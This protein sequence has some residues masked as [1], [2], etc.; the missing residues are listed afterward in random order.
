MEFDITDDAKPRFQLLSGL[1][2]P[3]VEELELNKVLIGACSSVGILF[4]AISW[5]QAGMLRFIC[6]WLAASFIAG[7]F[8][9]LS[10]T[11]GNCR[12]G[13]GQAFSDPN[14]QV[15]P[16]IKPEKRTKDSNR[17]SDAT[18]GKRLLKTDPDVN[19]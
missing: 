10:L 16:S 12:V 14:L 18:I 4:L 15:E 13:D 7:P 8:A 11:G 9:P 19:A 3:D 1:L 2:E 5:F 6:L 17:R